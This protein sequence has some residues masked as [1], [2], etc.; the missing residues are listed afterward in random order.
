MNIAWK[1]I[2]TAKD[3][4]LGPTQGLGSI[5]AVYNLSM[6]PFERYDM[7]FNGAEGEMNDLKT[8]PGRYA[9]EDNGWSAAVFSQTLAD[10]DKHYEVSQHPALPWRGFKR[11]DTGPAASQQPVAAAGSEQSAEGG[12]YGRLNRGRRHKV[13][14]ASA[15]TRPH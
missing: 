1:F 2:W 13:P 12:S 14:G 8:S 3:S 4:W 7:I 10:F 5:P 15:N 6:D 11:L 9:G